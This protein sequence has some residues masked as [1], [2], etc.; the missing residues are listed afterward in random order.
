MLKVFRI[1]EDWKD[2]GSSQRIRKT[3]LKVVK[4]RQRRK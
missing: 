1:P 4:F 2:Q 3:E